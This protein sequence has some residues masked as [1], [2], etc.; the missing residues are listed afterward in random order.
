MLPLVLYG[1]CVARSVDN[2]KAASAR[3]RI[4]ASHSVAPITDIGNL[5][6]RTQD[7]PHGTILETPC[8]GCRSPAGHSFLQPLRTHDT[9]NRIQMAKLSARPEGRAAA[10]PLRRIVVVGCAVLFV[11][12]AICVSVHAVAR[13]S[14]LSAAAVAFRS[15][16]D[17][18]ASKVFAD[19]WAH[20]RD[21]RI[22]AERVGGHMETSGAYPTR[23][24][25]ARLTDPLRSN[26]DRIFSGKSAPRS[27]SRVEGGALPY[28]ARSTMLGVG[29][30]SLPSFP[31]QLSIRYMLD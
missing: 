5:H 25:Y 28:S 6:Y 24:T 1:L 3:P 4:T 9:P 13:D 27:V 23:P 7:R 12:C 11:C 26:P 8:P 20:L 17:D 18:L 14:E 10:T 15:R 2:S 29:A 21:V 30:G 22:A 31:V 16:A 19:N